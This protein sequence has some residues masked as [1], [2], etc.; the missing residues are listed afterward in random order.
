[1]LKD[2]LSKLRVYF[3]CFQ[4]TKHNNNNQQRNETWRWFRKK[5]QKTG[6]EMPIL[7]E[8]VAKPE[9]LDEHDTGIPMD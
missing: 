1:M 2:S 8:K 5:K 6:R 3:S 4:K 9:G 7:G